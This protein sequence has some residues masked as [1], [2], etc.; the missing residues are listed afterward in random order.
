M[1]VWG[2]WGDRWRGGGGEEVG[3][4]L[5]GDISA[6]N[7]ETRFLS[8]GGKG[9][10]FFVQTASVHPTFPL[11]DLRLCSKSPTIPSGSA[12]GQHCSLTKDTGGHRPW[13]FLVAK[14]QG[15]GRTALCPNNKAVWFIQTSRWFQTSTREHCLSPGQEDLLPSTAAEIVKFV[16]ALMCH[17]EV[18]A[19]YGG[20]AVIG[21]LTPCRRPQC[22]D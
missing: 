15:C 13:G 4:P 21:C 17:L 22:Q 11:G 20:A 9:F 3:Q 1:R 2:G 18:E 19:G 16:A 8:V 10:L 14:G 7:Q 6:V 5:T 12:R